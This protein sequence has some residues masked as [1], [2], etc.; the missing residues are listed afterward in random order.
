MDVLGEF[1]K[2]NTMMNERLFEACRTLPP[3]QLDATAVGTYGT[4]GATLVHIANAQVGYASRLLDRERPEPLAEDP[5]PGFDALAERM[6][7]GNRQL[8]E[9][10][11]RG[12]QDREVTVRGDD[13]PG[14][15]NMNVSLFL[16]QAIN[17]STE[18]RQQVSTILTQLGIRPPEM[19][20]WTYFFDSGM[21]REVPIDAS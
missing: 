20:G 13:P 3:E 9:A 11:A 5:F 4:I 17:H 2:H 6:E 12:A 16:V 18:H 8:E 7:L 19:D 14:A 21:M 10:A 1:F 15:W